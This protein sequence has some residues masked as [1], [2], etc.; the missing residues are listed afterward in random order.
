MKFMHTRQLYF[1][2]ATFLFASLACSLV[3]APITTQQPVPTAIPTVA[4]IEQPTQE[5]TPEIGE[6]L[7]EED[8]ADNSNNW[9]VGADA[10]TESRVEDGKYKVRVLAPNDNFYWF[11]PPVSASEVDVTVD[12]E[13]TEGAMENAA[14]GFLCHFTDSN[15]F[16]R[17]RVA[18]DGTYAI[19]KSVN[20]EQSYIVDW[21]KSH[22]INQGV[23]ATNKIHVICNENHLTLYIN[24]AFMADV[25]DT[26]LTGGTFNLMVGAYANKREDKNPIGMNFS[27]LS[28]RKPLPWEHPTEALLVDSFDDNNNSWDVFEENGNSAQVENGQMVMKVVE[29]NSIYRVWPGIA[30]SNLDLTFDAVIQEGTQSNVSYGAACRYVNNDNYYSFS[31]DGD[32]YYTL[33]KKVKGTQ[34][35]LTDWTLSNAL[36]PGVGQTNRIRVVCSDSMLEIYANDQLV[37]SLQ[38]AE[39]TAGGFALQAGRFDKDDLPMSVTFDNI[40]VKY[41]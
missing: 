30:L 25:V 34:E 11:V 24:D 35:I 10:E 1:A 18:P 19:D 15:N 17:F 3:N 33:K 9:Y 37:T 36:K 14:Y 4:V 31:V 16:H 26:S 13:F 27:N 12:T 29:P 8:F 5:P 38:D 6:L 23:G 20:A 7:L 21:T 41:P 2:L 32:G 39:L 22:A 28:V 40:E